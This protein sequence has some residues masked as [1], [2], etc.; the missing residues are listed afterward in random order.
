[1]LELEL[2]RQEKLTGMIQEFTP[3]DLIFKGSGI[4][5]VENGSGETVTWD[6]QRTPRNV[7][8]FQGDHSPAKPQQ[9]TGMG[10]R[11]AKLG[12]IFISKNI[13]ASLFN[14]LR[15][16]GSDAV[17]KNASAQIAL[18]EKEFA[19]SMDRTEEF[20]V[21]SA[22]QGEITTTV[23]DLEV[24]PIDYGI[25]AANK[26]TYNSGTPSLN[27]GDWLDVS[28][29][30]ADA[31]RRF[32]KAARVATGKKITRGWISDLVQQALMKNERFIQIMRSTAEGVRALEEGSMGKF[33]GINWTVADH[34]YKDAANADVPY[35]PENVGVFSPEPSTDWGALR[36]G[37]DLIPNNAGD[38]FTEAMGRY[39]YS[40]MQK[41]PPGLT[42]Y[43]G[44]RVFPIIKKP[45]ALIHATVTAA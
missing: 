1:M 43:A 45:G 38:G 25:P 16:P 19:A 4:L 42:L 22:L 36:Y 6:I 13:K 21:A 39:S 10:Q 3:E 34:V 28:T 40:E 37:S 12:K 18:E 17:Q 32:K 29:D 2:L 8:G 31:I 30:I 41:N 5:P 20:L 23:D 44:L 14:Q 35:L 11:T 7:L 24:D 33:M 9:L 15:Q 27:I 26:F